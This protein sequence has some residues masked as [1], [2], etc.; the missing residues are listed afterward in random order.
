MMPEGVVVEI[1]A[2]AE[3]AADV[4]L[5]DTRGRVMPPRP[6]PR[7]RRGVWGGGL[8]GLVLRRVEAAMMN[9]C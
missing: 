4:G 7:P 8:L 6:L 1:E 2:R 3:V 9:R 5:V